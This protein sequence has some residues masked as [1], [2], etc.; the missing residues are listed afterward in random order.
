MA[1]EPGTIVVVE[2]D[3]HI[4]DLIDLYL[5]RDGHR[6]V[7][8]TDGV[9][10]LAAVERERPRLVVLDVGLPGSLDGFEICRRIR[11][12]SRVPVMMLTARD[13]EIDRV[14]GFELGADDYVTK[15]FSPREL[16]ARVKAIIRRADGPPPDT[17]GV[18]RAGQVEVDTGRREA[19]VQGRVVPLATREF[20]L[21]AHLARNRGLALSR[22]QLLDGVWGVGWYGD[23]RT[24][25]VHV[26]QL[27]K[28]FG[29]DL[30]LATVW[31]IGYRLD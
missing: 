26:G 12:T 6:V 17:S 5:R 13:E 18:L 31:G 22:Q 16:A 23:E 3:P 1:S 4:A 10:A 14:L 7:Q 8:V 27:R 24:V 20:D 19:R 15:P 28:K 11:D 9:A 30:P 29:S 2:D 25:D 21:L